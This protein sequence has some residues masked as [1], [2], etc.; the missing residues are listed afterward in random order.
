V[1]LMHTYS[2][3]T[4]RTQSPRNMSD[5]YPDHSDHLAAGRFTQRAYQQ[6][7]Q[8]Q[9]ANEVTIPISYYIGYPVHAM[10]SNVSGD[11]LQQKTAAFLAYAAF[12]GS[13]CGSVEQ[14]QHTATYGSYLARQYKLDNE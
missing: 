2:P 13:V 8:E 7:E 11:D 10:D 3:A 14:C 6:Y 5:V 9:Y 4:I 12:D 1:K